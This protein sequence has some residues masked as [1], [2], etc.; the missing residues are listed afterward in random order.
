LSD[1][2]QKSPK[3]AQKLSQNYILLT[4]FTCKELFCA[5]QKNRTQTLLQMLAVTL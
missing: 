2:D 1:Y 5:Y 4:H 3:M